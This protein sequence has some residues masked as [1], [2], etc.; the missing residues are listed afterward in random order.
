MAYADL[1]IHSKYSDGSHSPEEIVRIARA[2]NVSLISVCDHTLVQGTLEALGLIFSK[3]YTFQRST[4][5]KR[6]AAQGLQG[7]ESH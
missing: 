5:V 3:F 2:A 1:H 7:S 6:I 4:S